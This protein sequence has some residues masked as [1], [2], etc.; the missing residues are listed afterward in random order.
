M[1][2]IRDPVCLDVTGVGFV[3]RNMAK[4]QNP[5]VEISTEGDTVSL[6]TITTFKTQEIKFK[7]GEEFE[8]KRLDGSVCKSTVTLD[9]NQL[10]Q[11]QAAE[12]SCDIIREIIDGDKLKTVSLFHCIAA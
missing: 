9:G 4:V 7:L 10:I 8:E 1:F 12:K 5:T 11:H 6:K 3:M 2:A